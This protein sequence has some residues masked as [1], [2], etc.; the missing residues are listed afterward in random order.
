MVGSGITILYWRYAIPPIMADFK[1]DKSPISTTYSEAIKTKYKR[2]FIMK[3]RLWI[4]AAA[5]IIILLT[6]A[7]FGGG[8]YVYYRLSK[9]GPPAVDTLAN[10]PSSF[11]VTYNEYAT[12]DPAPYEVSSYEVISFPSRQSN[13]ALSGW[14]I[15]VD[16]NA[17]VVIMTHGNGASKKDAN[18]LIP[19]GM[20]A[21]NGFNVLMYDMQNYGE[22]GK[23]NGHTSAGNKEFQDVLGAWDYLIKVKGYQPD[24]IGLY[25]ASLGGATTLIAFGQEPRLAAAFIDSPFT[26]LPE[27]MK[28][29]LARHNIPTFFET[30]AI[31]MARL[32]TGDNLLAHSP[33][34]AINMDNGRPIF[35]VHGTGDT[36]ISVNQTRELVALAQAKGANLSV[37]MPD[38]VEHIGAMFVLTNQYEQ[39][40]VNF[41]RT[42]LK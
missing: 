27:L 8:Y 28:N 15:E 2:R 3:R 33:S 30:L 10:N 22:S 23:D 5:T 17:P 19:A 37:W 7:Y 20:L 24:R 4:I 41:F 25:G 18:V 12:F 31:L 29:E 34:D 13:V 39:K 26:N 38:G 14:Y 1:K 42:A 16:P 21:H 35:I 32:T 36:R 40:L 11:K 6:L 9:I